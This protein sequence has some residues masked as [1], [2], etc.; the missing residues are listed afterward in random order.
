MSDRNLIDQ[1]RP[2]NRR[3]NSAGL[4]LLGTVSTPDGTRA[5]L[6]QGD[7]VMRVTVG[8]TVNALTVTAIGQGEIYLARGAEQT[9]LHI[10]G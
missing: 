9:V 1:P 3:S 6:L 2:N 7:D 5:L 4:M 10:P 8:D